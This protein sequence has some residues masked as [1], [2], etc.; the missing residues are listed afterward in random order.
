MRRNALLLVAVM[1]VQ[2]AL[3]MQAGAF[4][5][6]PPTGPGD[7]T[8]SSTETA[9]LNASDQGLVQGHVKCTGRSSST[10]EVCSYGARRTDSETL[11][12]T[13][14]VASLFRTEV[15]FRRTRASVLTAEVANGA[16]LDING[17]RIQEACFVQLQS[18]DWSLQDV[19][20]ED[21]ILRAIPPTSPNTAS[22]GT[23]SLNWTVDGVDFVNIT[24]G[25]VVQLQQGGI[26]SWTTTAKALPMAFNN[27]TVEV[28][29]T[30]KAAIHRTTP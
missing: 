8:I 26:G 30:T 2:V 6:T 16:S 12:C 27:F 23:P 22:N 4:P 11:W 1:L 24:R 9:Y 29:C 21:S 13:T 14:V 18:T 19:H 20:F 25:P 7:W 15:F 5:T 10:V 28:T 3:P 17:G